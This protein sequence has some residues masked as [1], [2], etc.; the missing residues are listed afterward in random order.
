MANCYVWLSIKPDGLPEMSSIMFIGPE[1]ECVEWA[2]RAT[3]KGVVWPKVRHELTSG[4]YFRNRP[5]K[6][7]CRLIAGEGGTRVERMFII[8]IND[9]NEKVQH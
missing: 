2:K 4:F 3:Y 8:K 7:V 1:P 9:N 5:N 6:V